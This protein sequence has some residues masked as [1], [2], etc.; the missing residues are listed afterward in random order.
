MEERKTSEYPS[1]LLV[2]IVA[3][4]SPSVSRE[5]LSALMSGLRGFAA[6]HAEDETLEWE[7]ICYDGFTPVVAKSFEDSDIAPV[8]A[9]RMPLFGRACR[10]AADRLLARAEALRAE[11]HTVPR[12]WLFLL[13]DGFTLDETEEVAS[14]LDTKEHEGALMYLPFRLSHT[15]THERMQAFDRIKHM[16]EVKEGSTDRLLAFVEEMLARRMAL[17][18]DEPMQFQKTDFEGWALL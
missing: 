17:P 2:S 13:S 15:L 18:A 8:Y 3:D 16:I 7:L 12:P 9:G 5:R 10:L 11:G 14:M 4:N 6:A 1:R